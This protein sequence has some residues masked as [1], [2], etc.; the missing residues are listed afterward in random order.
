MMFSE[1]CESIVLG[2]IIPVLMHEWG[3]TTFLKSVLIT[4]LFFG[5][6]LGN[7]LQTTADIYGRYRIMTLACIIN[8]VTGL[9]SAVAGNFT[10][11]CIMRLLYG[12]GI[13]IVLPLSSTFI[14]EVTPAA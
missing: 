4:S 2:L 9:L 13:G 1:G 7:L 10:F 5:V 6:L 12:L 8:I 14:A 3:V 11:F